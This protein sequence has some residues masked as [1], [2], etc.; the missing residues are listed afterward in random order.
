VLLTG[1][2]FITMG[3]FGVRLWLGRR[4]RASAAQAANVQST[5]VSTSEA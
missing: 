5:Q 4:R 1:I 3:V 2:W